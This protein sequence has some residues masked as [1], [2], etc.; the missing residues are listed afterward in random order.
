M[1]TLTKSAGHRAVA[2]S[3]LRTH[4]TRSSGSESNKSRP[5]AKSPSISGEN[6]L[7]FRQ[8]V[9]S[10]AAATSTLRLFRNLS[11]PSSTAHGSAAFG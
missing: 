7:L 2:L 10:P 5:P 11:L 1:R 3:L 4:S 8:S 9:L 6:P